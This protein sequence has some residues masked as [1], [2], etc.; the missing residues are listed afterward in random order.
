MN[1]VAIGGGLGGGTLSGGVGSFVVLEVGAA[2]SGGGPTG[3]GSCA[4]AKAGQ[5]KKRKIAFNTI[6]MGGH[7]GWVGTR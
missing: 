5:I 3:E 1:I 7:K 2:R 4:S 6:R